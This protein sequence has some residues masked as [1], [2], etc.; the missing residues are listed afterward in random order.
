MICILFFCFF[1]HIE[2]ILLFNGCSLNGGTERISQVQY[3]KVWQISLCN[4]NTKCSDNNS[5]SC[6][7]MIK[8]G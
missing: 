7:F 4:K 2:Q 5:F 6:F 1:S 8:S 3:I